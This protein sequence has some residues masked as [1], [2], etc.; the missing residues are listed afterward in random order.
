MENKAK[1]CSICG[2]LLTLDRFRKTPF[3]PDGRA[4]YCKDCAKSKR[5]EKAGAP[6]EGGGKSQVLGHIITR[7]A[8]RTAAARI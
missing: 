4:G 6:I 7:V 8:G 1:N 3:S 2:R 5:A